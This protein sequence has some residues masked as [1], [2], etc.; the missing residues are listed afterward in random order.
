MKIRQHH[1]RINYHNFFES[2]RSQIMGFDFDEN[3]RLF[4]GLKEI[5]SFIGEASFFDRF[6]LAIANAL[7]NEEAQEIL[8]N[9]SRILYIFEF[10]S[11]TMPEAF[12]HEI[13][14]FD[15][16]TNFFSKDCEH[17]W[18]ISQNTDMGKTV[19]VYI[20]IG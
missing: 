8:K 18:A 17:I 6:Y 20:L 9:S 7:N 19:K 12:V 10:D 1:D 13:K 15:Y 5:H 4:Q 2:I 11:N 16:A 14:H 3:L